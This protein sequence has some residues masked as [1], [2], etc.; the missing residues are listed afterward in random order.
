M[1]L[2]SSLDYATV[3][4]VGMVLATV[5]FLLGVIII[6]SKWELLGTS[7]SHGFVHVLTSSSCLSRFCSLSLS[8]SSQAR[9]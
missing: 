5:M 2:P 6:V 3:Q 8:L 9:R 7:G 4:T 1:S